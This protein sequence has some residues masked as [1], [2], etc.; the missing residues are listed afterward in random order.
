MVRPALDVGKRLICLAALLLGA[1]TVVADTAYL[2]PV[3]D[4]SLIEIVPTNNLGS[5]LFLTAGTT[6]VGTRNRALVRFDPSAVLPRGARIVASEMSIEV[7]GRPSDG[8]AAEVFELRRMLRSWGEGLGMSPD[9]QHPG[10]GAPSQAGEAT[11]SDRF[12]GMNAPWHV[13]GGL[14]GVDFV[15]EGSGEQTL[16]GMADSPYAFASNPRM[17]ADIQAWLESPGSNFGWMLLPRDESVRFTA[18]RIG[19]REDPDRTPWL[20]VEFIPPPRIT[21]ITRVEAGVRLEMAL[22][23]GSLGAIEATSQLGPSADWIPLQSFGPAQI[24]TNLSVLDPAN[25]AQRFYRLRFD[26]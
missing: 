1:A 25:A 5:S 3:A 24:A 23:A 6:Q 7:V 4:T 2:T 12:T 8:F 18:R 19:S 22:E 9:P 16:Y 26:R 10:L 14:A 17:V 11:W 21:G 15:T 20:T 13:A